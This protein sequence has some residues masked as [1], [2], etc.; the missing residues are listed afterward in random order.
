MRGTHRNGRFA[1]EVSQILFG[2]KK[3]RVMAYQFLW[4]IRVG[5]IESRITTR[6]LRAFADYTVEYISKLIGQLCGDR[7]E[8]IRKR[9]YQMI[10]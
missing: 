6:H 5:L 3:I 1:G 2:E 7:A 9:R 4:H 8:E 10:K